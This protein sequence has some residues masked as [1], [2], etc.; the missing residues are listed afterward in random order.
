MPRLTLSSQSVAQNHV[1]H[2]FSLRFPNTQLAAKE[3]TFVHIQGNITISLLNEKLIEKTNSIMLPIVR[4]PEV[5]IETTVISYLAARPSRDVII[6]AR[7]RVTQ[8]FWY[9][10]R[11]RFELVI[12]PTIISEI[13]RGNT[14]A[15]QHRLNLVLDITR[16]PMSGAISNLTENLLNTGAVP[17]SAESDATHIA[18]AA[19]HDIEYLATWNY[20]HIVNVHKRQHIEQV[21]RDSGF[22]PAIICTPAELIEVN[23]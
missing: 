7:Q 22:R 5:Y 9:E 20:K 11:D 1:F 10:H 14:E 19:I 18:I 8:E 4:K 13:R 15:A 6:A 21:C 2:H 17:R 16:L 12:S 3:L 23:L